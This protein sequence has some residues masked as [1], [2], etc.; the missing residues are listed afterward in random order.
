VWRRAWRKE[1][2]KREIIKIDK[3]LCKE[4]RDDS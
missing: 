4:K 2:K 3:I 1:E